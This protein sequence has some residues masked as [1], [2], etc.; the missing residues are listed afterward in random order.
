MV[1]PSLSH[2]NTTTPKDLGSASISKV[3]S[4]GALPTT[5]IP[6]HYE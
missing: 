6:L 3:K 2:L 4:P 5:E 1:N